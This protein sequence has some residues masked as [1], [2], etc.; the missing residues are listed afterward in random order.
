MKAS[1]IFASLCVAGFLSS[2]AFLLDFDEL[3]TETGKDASVGGS[4][5]SSGGSAGISGNAGTA[6]TGG[7]AAADA[8]PE[9]ATAA[10]CDDGDAFTT[11]SCDKNVCKY[12]PFGKLIEDGF[13]IDSSV[14]HAQRVTAAAG[15]GRFYISVHRSHLPSTTYAT[16]VTTFAADTA[17]AS[18]TLSLDTLFPSP[19]GGQ[20]PMPISAAGLLA[21]AAGVHAF[22]ATN[23]LGKIDPQVWYV[24]LDTKAKPLAAPKMISKDYDLLSTKRYPA[25]ERVGSDVV[26]YWVGSF[27]K[28]LIAGPTKDLGVFPED[29]QFAMPVV[30][31]T[32][33]RAFFLKNQDDKSFY[34]KIGSQGGAL[35]D[36]TKTGGTS[37]GSI[38][39]TSPLPGVAVVGYSSKLLGNSV[40]EVRLVVCDDSTCSLTDKCEL[41]TA[42]TDG[43]NP[44]VASTVASGTP[45]SG[46]RVRFTSVLPVASDTKG[47]LALILSFFDFGSAGE[48]GGAYP[49]VLVA[50]K[51]G[52]KSE[53]PDYPAVAILDDRILVAWIDGATGAEQLHVRRYKLAPP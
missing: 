25:P 34:Y 12:Q 30:G 13:S 26:A 9:C 15:P 49:L 35:Q 20:P 22:F 29:V 16:A 44:A 43:R 10:E 42:T 3:Q 51:N 41:D 39:A 28:L 27:G 36:C 17:G 33:P 11:D 47:D 1:K 50:S 46:V 38:V 2:C 40:S 21:D 8:G 52:P 14:P 53:T 5:G 23:P 37:W 32:Q 48:N 31:S 7:D 24:Q 45:K 18:D 4:A 19:E 6:G